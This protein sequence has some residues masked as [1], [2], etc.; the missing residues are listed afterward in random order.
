MG[1]GRV[2]GL[3]H[4]GAPEPSGPAHVSTRLELPLNLPR[5]YVRE[6]ADDQPLEVGTQAGRRLEPAELAQHA[7]HG[8]EQRGTAAADDVFAVRRRE[9][10]E[11][12][13]CLA[14]ARPFQMFDSL[15][16]ISP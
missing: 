14:F 16:E 15:R 10:R 5:G 6:K 4:I 1:R 2:D 8:L 12:A 3:S 11:E 13:A 7:V 9:C